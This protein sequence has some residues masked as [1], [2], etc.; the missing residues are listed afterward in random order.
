[1]E[2]IENQ[3]I[4][5]FTR[6]LYIVNDV[7]TSLLM[8]ILNNNI[9]EALFWCYEL[10]YSGYILDVFEMINNI[11]NEFYSVFNPHLSLFLDKIQTDWVNKENCDCIIG[12]MVY[13]LINREH[14]ISGFVEKYS[15]TPFNL[16]Y[17]EM[18]KPDHKF[19]VILEDKD[20]AKYKTVEIGENL[21][22]HQLLKHVSTYA[23]H[24]Y[25]NV[26]FEHEHSTMAF[27]ELFDIYR[28]HWLYY[29]S[30]APIWAERIEKYKGTID[31]ETKKIVFGNEELEEEFYNRYNYEPDEQLMAIVIKHIGPQNEKKWTWTDFYEKYK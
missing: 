1:M 20:I 24:E 21:R 17:R 31:H 22:G 28:Y 6:Y 3:N 4:L 25:A 2:P 27:D 7:K 13:N 26:I 8:S 29:A 16:V 12:T 19:Y 30:F 18:R 23:T 14:S 10:Y 5:A 9:D 15:N 11:Y